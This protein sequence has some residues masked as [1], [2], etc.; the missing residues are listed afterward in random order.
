MYDF[1]DD[2]EEKKKKGKEKKRV[3]SWDFSLFWGQSMNHFYFPSKIT[4]KN[5]TKMQE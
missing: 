4:N 3:K 1:Y 2:M 5:Y